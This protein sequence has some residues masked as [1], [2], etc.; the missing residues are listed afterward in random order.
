[1]FVYNVKKYIGSYIA[2]MDGIDCLVFTA[3]IGEN[4]YVVRKA[5]CDN[6]DYFGIR[7]DET[8]NEK[9]NDG[10]IHDITAKDSRVKVL[11]IPT[12]EEL[13]IAR[14]TKEL[15]ETK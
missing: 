4:T 12:N 11:I 8:A 6:M 9:K 2:A 1:M 3:G 10:T 13:V 5:I 14:E 15:L 7:I